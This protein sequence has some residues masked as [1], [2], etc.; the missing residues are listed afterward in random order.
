MEEIKR[1]NGKLILGDG[2]VTGHQHTMREGSVKMFR[3][4]EDCMILQLPV[5]A[6]LRHEKGD[7]P[8][9]HRDM[10]ITAGDNCVT[11]KRQWAPDGWSKV[12]D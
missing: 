4:G 1:V 2:A 9:E 8:A 6:L 3:A 10:L 7:V 12:E 11:T 5:D